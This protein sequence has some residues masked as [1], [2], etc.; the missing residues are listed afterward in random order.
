MSRSTKFMRTKMASR[1]KCAQQ[2]VL[3]GRNGIPDETWKTQKPPFLVDLQNQARVAILV[4]I[5]FI[6]RD[7]LN[8]SYIY[9]TSTEVG[10]I[11]AARFK[12]TF[13]IF[14]QFIA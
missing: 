9:S 8:F 10:V 13:P 11:N 3:D 1:K 12:P 6:D 7:I 14:T 4:C 5:N 2:G